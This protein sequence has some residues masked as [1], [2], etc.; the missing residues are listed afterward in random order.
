MQDAVVELQ[1]LMKYHPEIDKVSIL[2]DGSI[3]INFLGRK[4]YFSDMIELLTWT[5]KNLKI[6]E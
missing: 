5:E 6:R 3:G 1:G 2:K 4:K